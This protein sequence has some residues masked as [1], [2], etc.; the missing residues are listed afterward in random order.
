M[1]KRLISLKLRHWTNTLHKFPNLM[2]LLDACV[3]TEKDDDR[4]ITR[5]IE[6]QDNE[7]MAG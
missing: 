6:L 1:H 3:P 2:K 5:R 4:M 7:M